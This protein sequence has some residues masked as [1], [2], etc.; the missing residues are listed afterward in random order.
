MPCRIGDEPGPRDDREEDQ[1][2][3]REAKHLL[4]VGEREDEVRQRDRRDQ[5][6]RGHRAGLTAPHGDWPLQVRLPPL[7]LQIRAQENERRA[8]AQLHRELDQ[9]G[10][11]QP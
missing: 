7:E 1:L 4:V 8:V 5:G 10:V 11:R 2:A 3:P 9:E 6:D